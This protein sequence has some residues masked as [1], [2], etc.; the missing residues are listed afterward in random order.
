[1]PDGHGTADCVPAADAVAAAAVGPDVGCPL[2]EAPGLRLPPLDDFEDECPDEHPTSANATA[3]SNPPHT[4]FDLAVDE[5]AESAGFRVRRRMALL[6]V[7][8]SEA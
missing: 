3:S 4:S 7:A 2:A 6:R 8:D 5:G 1:V